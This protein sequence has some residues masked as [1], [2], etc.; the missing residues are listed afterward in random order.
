LHYVPRFYLEGFQSKSGKLWCYD[1][2]LDKA[3]QQSPDRLGGE[4]L[5]YDLPEADIKIGIPQFLEKW[6]NPLEAD[7]ALALK[8]WRHRLRAAGE[9]SP[10]TDELAIMSRFM[11]VQDLRTPKSRKAVVAR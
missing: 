9:F 1:K 4:R 11:A 2:V 10:T 5:F 7:A 8:T 3:Y 6:F